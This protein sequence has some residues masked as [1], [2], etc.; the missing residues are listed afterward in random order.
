MRKIVDSDHPAHAQYRL[1]ICTPV[2]Q[3]VVQMYP[4]ILLADNDGPGQTAQM[5]RLI[6]VFAARICP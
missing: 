1:G 3:S 4:M 2:I 6:W 5:R